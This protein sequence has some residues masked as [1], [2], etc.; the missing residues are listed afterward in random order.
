MGLISR[1]RRITVSRI[2]NFLNTVEDPEVL[3]P[4]LVREMEDQVRAAISAETKALAAQKTAE[5]DVGRIRQKL[6]RMARGA[7][8][9]VEKG[10]NETA[11]DAIRTQI[12]L[13]SDLKFQEDAVSRAERAYEDAKDA[14]MQIEKQLEELRTKKNEILTRARIASTQKKIEKTVSGRASSA[15]SILDAVVRLESKVEESE[16]ELEIRRS[17]DAG[18]ATPS[19]DRRLDELEQNDEIEKRLAELKK[20]IG[21]SNV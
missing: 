9:A 1:I 8:L 16:A 6:D 15:N 13:E 17:M 3:F 5:R 11:R 21:N 14:R 20:K 10:E 2:E 19:L 18:G 12:T 4:Q 7:E